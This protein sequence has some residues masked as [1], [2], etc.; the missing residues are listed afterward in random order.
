[1]SSKKF[2][3]FDCHKKFFHLKKTKAT[4]KRSTRR[5]LFALL[6]HSALPRTCKPC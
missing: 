1:M 4:T 6:Q 3:S 5:K 2:K